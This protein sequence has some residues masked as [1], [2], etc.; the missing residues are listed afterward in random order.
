MDQPGRRF[1]VRDG[2]TERL[3]C[4]A[5][6][7]AVI[8][9]LLV[10]PGRPFEAIYRLAYPDELVEAAQ[11]FFGALTAGPRLSSRVMSSHATTALS[12]V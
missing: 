3:F 9:Y 12:Q 5:P 11:S 7:G 10:E 6:N 8:G 2:E 1:R 4:A